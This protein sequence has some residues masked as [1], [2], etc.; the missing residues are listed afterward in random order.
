M[1]SWPSAL[2]SGSQPLGRIVNWA[3]SEETEGKP[4]WTG[5]EWGKGRKAEG[6]ARGSPNPMY[7]PEPAGAKLLPPDLSVSAC[8]DPSE[9]QRDQQRPLGPVG[10]GSASVGPHGVLRVP[11]SPLSS[12]WFWLSLCVSSHPPPPSLSPAP[13]SCL[14]QPLHSHVVCSQGSPV[15]SP[16]RMLVT[17]GTYRIN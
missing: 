8:Q 11:R 10:C 14:A 12:V 16:R 13:V 4:T 6:L 17:A 7:G 9:S 3:G 1:N 5:S 2:C 15:L